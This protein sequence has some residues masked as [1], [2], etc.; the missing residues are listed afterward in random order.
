MIKKMFKK[1]KKKKKNKKKSSI[2]YNTT[3]NIYKPFN[4]SSIQSTDFFN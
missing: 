1:K 3:Q 4:S 2:N